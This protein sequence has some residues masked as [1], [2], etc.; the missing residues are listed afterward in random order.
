MYV[1][2][3]TRKRTPYPKGKYPR[4]EE[5]RQKIKDAAARRKAAGLPGPNAGKKRDP[6]V[7]ARMAEAT[8]ERNRLKPKSDPLVLICQ[9]CGCQYTP[10]DNRPHQKFCSHACRYTSG[11]GR[12]P[13]K[14]IN[15]E[16][17]CG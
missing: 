15:G 4:T 8:R 5:H 14:I 7:V 12:P 11:V 6:A 16:M 17:S 10:K 9:K 1:V 3:M 13:K 2:G